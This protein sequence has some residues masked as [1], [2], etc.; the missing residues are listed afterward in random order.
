MIH[1][2]TGKGKGKT[3]AAMGLA[4][5]AL[6]A[7][8]SVVIIRFLKGDKSSGEIKMLARL[9]GARIFS[10]GSGRRV[11][12]GKVSARDRSQAIEG[13]KKARR[14]MAS[15]FSGLLVLDE[16]NN[17]LAAGLLPAREA[18]TELKRRSKQMEIV[19]TGRNAP[20]AVI[21]VADY[22]TEMK[23]IKHP[24]RRGCPARSGV[25]Y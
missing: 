9:S 14:L 2:Y 6:G 20:D 19:L 13:W 25:E 15:R 18:A 3:T 11:Q 24:W 12:L 1:V 22:V 10:F 4:L 21:S 8:K 16:I 5:R 23:K 7:R 17:A